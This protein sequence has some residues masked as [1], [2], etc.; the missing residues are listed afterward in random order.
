MVAVTTEL[1]YE[2]LKQLQ[3]RMTTLEGGLRENTAAI[4][5]LRTHVIALH[6]VVQKIYAVLGRH[7]ARLERIQRRLDIVEP[8]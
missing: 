6:Q 3:S 7:E 8:A 4:N 5:A 2:I 1:I